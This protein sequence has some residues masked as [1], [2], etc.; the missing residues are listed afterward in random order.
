MR[1][2]GNGI[3]RERVDRAHID[4][5][6]RMRLCDPPD[7]AHMRVVEGMI[8]GGEHNERLTVANMRGIV[9]QCVD[10]ARESPASVKRLVECVLELGQTAM[11]RHPGDIRGVTE[12]ERHLIAASQ[13]Q[14]REHAQGIRCDAIRH[15]VRRA[16]LG[17]LHACVQQQVHTG[18]GETL[19]LRNHCPAIARAD[20]PI[21]LSRRIAHLIGTNVQQI[22]I[23]STSCGSMLPLKDAHGTAH[24]G[25]AQRR[26]EHLDLASDRIRPIGIM[27]GADHGTG[28]T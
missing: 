7:C 17:H 14:R 18:A 2:R 5:H 1:P 10:I 28:T 6:Q 13:A 9:E 12:D 19:A 8:V 26:A 11:E 22:V 21:D 23:A 20:L 16:H 27:I 15:L 4:Q 25:Q 3:A 24:G